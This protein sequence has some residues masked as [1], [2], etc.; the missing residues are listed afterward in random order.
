V[1]RALALLLAALVVL[2]AVGPAEAR[3]GRKHHKHRRALHG[4]AK[5]ARASLARGLPARGAAVPVGG[6]GA[7]APYPAP[8]PTPAP[9]D[10]PAPPPPP[11]P[12]VPGATGHS[13]QARTDDS[14]PAHLKLLL[15]ATTVLAG[16][17]RIE[18]NN[19]YAEDPH[20]LVVERADG[21]GASFAFDELAAGA[22][23]A[24]T[25]ALTAGTWRLRCTIPTHA[26]RGMS[27][28]LAVT[29]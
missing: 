20:D 22:V 12:P 21:T 28:T 1:R 15:S 3:R 10:D 6:P 13:L 23:R 9:G 27:A 19:A 29:P 16:D 4:H 18:F 26:E 2:T 5:A 8:A 25:V 24:R 7:P 14:D 17:V 11:P